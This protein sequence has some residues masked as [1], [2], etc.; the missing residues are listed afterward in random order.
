MVCQYSDKFSPC[1]L[2]KLSYG[3]GIRGNAVEFEDPDGLRLP[4]T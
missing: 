3:L 2:V 4:M 1:H